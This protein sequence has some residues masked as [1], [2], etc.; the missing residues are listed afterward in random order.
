MPKYENFIFIKE[1]FVYNSNV[2]GNFDK[3]PFDMDAPGIDPTLH[4]E[5]HVKIRCHLGGVGEHP[6]T[7]DSEKSPEF[8]PNGPLQAMNGCVGIIVN[9][10]IGKN[11]EVHLGQYDL[12]GTKGCSLLVQWYQYFIPGFG[13][14]KLI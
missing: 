14:S 4:R 3:K 11:M 8:T 12:H 13:D 10:N 6:H 5:H 2:G 7:Q 1:V 9:Y